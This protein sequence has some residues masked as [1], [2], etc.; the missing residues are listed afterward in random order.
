MKL[1]TCHQ[2]HH[3]ER[4]HLEHLGKTKKQRIGKI[5][6]FTIIFSSGY[7]LSANKTLE[8]LDRATS[9]HEIVDVQRELENGVTVTPSE[10]KAYI[11]D[12]SKDGQKRY[13]ALRAMHKSLPKDQLWSQIVRDC[14]MDSDRSFR[15]AC[16]LDMAKVNDPKAI[17]FLKEKFN[18]SK[19]DSCLRMAAG[20]SLAANGDAAG[21]EMALK[22]IVN[23][24]TCAD[25]AML[26]LANL[27]ANDVIPKLEQAQSQTPSN[28]IRNDC[29]LAILRIETQNHSGP[30]LIKKLKEV[31]NED[32]FYRAQQW[33]ARY[34]A[35][36][37]GSDA[38]DAL[39]GAYQGKVATA[40]EAALMGLKLG[41]EMNSW[42][43]SEVENRLRK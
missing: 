4:H 39:T 7:V 26:T 41:I 10:L 28:S 31:F 40:S 11:R 6:L 25:F 34:L 15:L 27:H 37:G 23:G 43:E 16:V 8:K 12:K 38:L 32:G 13:R 24:D 29:K 19:E 1:V 3:L 33:S 42:T 30:E 21:K 18:E 17:A 5:G 2:P 20:S 22:T 36:L 35:T 9:S 14:D